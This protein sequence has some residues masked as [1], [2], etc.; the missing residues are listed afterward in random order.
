M[1]MEH[2]S[3]VFAS[4]PAGPGKSDGSG[5]AITESCFTGAVSSTDTLPLY[6][7]TEEHQDGPVRDLPNWSPGSLRYGRA[8]PPMHVGAGPRVL[9]STS[10]S[11]RANAEVTDVA[12][13]VPILQRRD[14]REMALGSF[15]NP[16]SVDD[17]DD[18]VA[19]TMAG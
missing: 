2:L 4:N 18:D 8:P 3:G 1:V 14:D 13:P 17:G 15:K 11:A 16:I 10:H 12:M 19:M 6:F 9:G 7:T 5:N